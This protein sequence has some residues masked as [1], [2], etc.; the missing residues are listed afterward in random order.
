MAESE[1][2]EQKTGKEMTSTERR[3]Q[4]ECTRKMPR[5]H[6]EIAESA[7]L[8]LPA[9]ILGRM[10]F[11]TQSPELQRQRL[12]QLRLGLAMG[13]TVIISSAVTCLALTLFG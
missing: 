9:H 1:C 7:R 2:M 11:P 12:R 13:A 10:L 5:D 6:V 8:P 3:T 4:C